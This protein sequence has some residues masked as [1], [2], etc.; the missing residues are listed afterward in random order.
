MRELESLWNE[1]DKKSKDKPKPT[2]EEILEE[3][4]SYRREK[5]KNLT[6]N[7]RE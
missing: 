2:E 5:R 3:I 4:Q 7:L 1:I 6:S